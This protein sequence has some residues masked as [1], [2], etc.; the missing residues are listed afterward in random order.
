MVGKD[1]E[2]VALLILTIVAC[3][4]FLAEIPE[5]GEFV[6]GELVQDVS[7]VL[8]RLWIALP[9]KLLRILASKLRSKIAKRQAPWGVYDLCCDVSKIRRRRRVRCRDRVPWQK[10]GKGQSPLAQV[11]LVAE[12]QMP[13]TRMRAQVRPLRSE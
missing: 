4:R 10:V 1:L 8:R 7:L 12:C 3:V 5:F 2:D 11:F 13:R 9:S 6:G